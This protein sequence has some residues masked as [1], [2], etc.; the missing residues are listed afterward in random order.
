MRNR[1]KVEGF[2]Y[3]KDEY[4]FR[5]YLDIKSKEQESDNPDLMVIMMNPGS[6]SPLD[7][8][9]NNTVPSEAVP[10]NTQDQIMKVMLKNNLRYARI[11]NLSDLRT[12][13]SNVLYKFLK[14]KESQE[15]DHSIFC[16][17]RKNDFDL[18]FRQNV[19]VIYGWGVDSALTE[20]SKIAV[21]KIN[22]PEPSG[23]KKAGTK[24][25]YYHPLPRIYNK[26][27]EWVETVS[28]MLSGRLKM[29]VSA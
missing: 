7:G 9:D 8:I 2:F 5:K 15:I 23:L 20:L 14:S 24:Y 6:S 29:T 4:K 11:L 27:I 3:E 25:A 18:L 10:D 12:P 1:F 26:Q 19:P 28:K 17:N 22:H 13:D 21:K 16:K